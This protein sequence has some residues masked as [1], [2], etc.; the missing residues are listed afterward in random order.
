VT[1]DDVLP[2]GWAWTSLKEV[3]TWRG[4]GTP[5]KAIPEFWE[6]GTIH[7]VSPKDMKRLLIDSAQDQI[8]VEAVKE[9][10]ANL[11]PK[12]SVLMVTRSGILE[13]TFPVAV[14]VIEVAVNQDLKALTPHDGVSATYLAYFLR[15]RGRAILDSCS[16]DGTTVS[17]IDSDRL[18][19]Y[20]LALAPS[21]EQERIVSKIDE[22]FSSID[23][24]ERALE[25]I[26][27][28]VELYRQSVLKAAVTGELTREWREAHAGELESGESLLARILE[29]H[30]KAWEKSELDKM[31]ARG[32]RIAN[33][34]WKKRYKAAAF[35]DVTNLPGLPSGWTWASPVQLEDA[36]SNALT[37]GP[38]GS[39]LK[40]SDYKASGV[41]L[42]FVRNIRSQQFGGPKA[43][44]VTHEKATELTSHKARA[45][46][47]LI[48][49]MGEPPGDACVYPIG[50]PDAV[51]TSDCIKWTL[52]EIL[53][54]TDYFA[55]FINSH[56]GRS[57]IG[58]ITK[59]VAQQKVSLD[60]FRQIAIAL[61]GLEEQR[62]MVERLDVELQRMAALESIIFQETRRATTTRQSLLNAAFSGKLVP[63]ESTD[64][65]AS[66]LLECIASGRT[67]SS[68]RPAKKQSR[69]KKA[70]A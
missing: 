51:I 13:H 50:S 6:N 12:D 15:A 56:L 54:S 49:K 31:K 5:S 27:K 45:G 10:A 60:R 66:A 16:K 52:H 9:S 8:T 42:I 70:K 39:N 46:D 21:G 29:G 14:N 67:M 34:D 11:I 18:A 65:P 41:P 7:W 17:S 4:G 22:L 62:E 30:R 69:K 25:R 47:I 33:S 57:Q 59:G 19:A 37:I 26:R 44:Y 64:E 23:E 68:K 32:V 63:Q 20:P 53:R 1:K 3:G 28:L 2:S 35:P 38:F 24:G 43:K 61:P 58:A 48:T 36:I 40:V 55:Y